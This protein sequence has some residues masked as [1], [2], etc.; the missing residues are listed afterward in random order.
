[1]AFKRRT[2]VRSGSGSKRATQ[3][4]SSADVTGFSGLAA[5]AAVFDQTFPFGEDATIIRTRGTLWVSSDQVAASEEPFGALGMSVVTD[6][7]AAIGVTALPTPITD[8]SSDNWF[9]WM[10]WMASITLA[11]AVS[12]QSNPY[13]A[14]PFDSKAMRKVDDGD[15]VAVVLENSSGADGV[16]FIL[17]FRMLVKLHG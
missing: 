11:T 7:A 8:E 10:P 2:F 16:R 13:V 14:Y 12:I 17:K 1:M 5:S 9:L 6:Q 3:W 4:L 15:N